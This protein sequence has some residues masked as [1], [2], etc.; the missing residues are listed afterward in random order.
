MSYERDNVLSVLGC[1]PRLHVNRTAR[2]VPVG[3]PLSDT[4]WMTLKSRLCAVIDRVLHLTRIDAEKDGR[5]KLWEY[6]ES[7]KH[8]SLSEQIIGIYEFLVEFTYVNKIDHQG[9]E[10]SGRANTFDTIEPIVN[11][12]PLPVEVGS[13]AADG[14]EDAGVEQLEEQAAPPY[15]TREMM[16]IKRRRPTAIR[17][18]G[19]AGAPAPLGDGTLVEFG[20]TDRTAW[21][22]YSGKWFI[23]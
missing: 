23:F 12:L 22:H 7:V 17:P 18:P 8:L 1:N 10:E 5:D 14:G 2:N 3:L 4:E 11:K 15:L 9:W 16:N 20:G 13:R 19:G 6:A 21:G